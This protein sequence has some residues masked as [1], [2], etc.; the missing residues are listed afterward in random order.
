MAGGDEGVG[1]E[2]TAYFWVIISALE[3][4]KFGIYIIDIAAV[5]QRVAFT[6]GIRKGSSSG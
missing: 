5:A 3:V 6:E 4:K 1:V 2:E